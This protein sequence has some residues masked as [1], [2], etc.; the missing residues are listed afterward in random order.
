MGN[1]V[2]CAECVQALRAFDAQLRL[3]RASRII[4]ACVDHPAVMGGGLEAEARVALGDSNTEPGGCEFYA[5]ARPVTP[6]PTINVST[7][8]IVRLHPRRALMSNGIVSVPD[9][10]SWRRPLC[11]FL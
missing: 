7:D 3:H 5:A 6:P 8:S 10:S 4:D 11:V 2:R 1:V 9:E